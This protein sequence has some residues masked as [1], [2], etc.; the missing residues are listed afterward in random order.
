MSTVGRYQIIEE[1]GRGAMGVVYK[2]LD[3]AI[4]RTVAIKTI[5]LSDFHDPIERGRVRDRLLLEAQ[6]AGVLSHPNIVTIYDVLEEPDSAHI[7]MEYVSGHSLEQMRRDAHL[8][9]RAL[10]LQFL[11]QVAE[12][13]DYAHAKGVIHRDVKPANIIISDAKSADAGFAKEPLAKIADFGI[14]KFISQE[15]THSGT[16]MGTPNYMSPEQIQGLTLDGR[17]DQFSFAVVVYELLTGQK[18]FAAD[19]LPALFY[20]ICKQEPKPPH[21]I[22]GSL[23]EGVDGVLKRA[24][25]READQR[26]SSCSE[27]IAALSLAM[28]GLPWVR[29]DGRIEREPD[30]PRNSTIRKT[31]LILAMCLA[32]AAAIALIGRWNSGSSAL[33]ATTEGATESVSKAPENLEADKRQQDGL[34]KRAGASQAEKLKSKPVGGVI[35]PERNGAAAN[36]PVSSEVELLSEPPGAKLLVDG[37]AETTCATP[38]TLELSSGR[39]TLTAELPGYDLARRIFTVPENDSVFISLTKSMGVLMINSEPSTA[40]VIVDGTNCGQTPVTVHLPAGAHHVMLINGARQHEETV[41]IQN[42][43]FA[44]RTIRWD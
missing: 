10:L 8:P 17:S 21:E 27:F 36:D 24:L 30:D 6:S 13:L 29:T 4:G 15:M 39:H 18:P 42:E 35:A 43:G 16:M 44:A 3:P 26:F 37:R 12:A 32:I 38:C 40:T 20:Q 9:N 23:G 25:S 19:S 2:A 31:A 5:R 41:V 11:R 14:A 33:S 22:D 1:L 34:K 28:A 7:F